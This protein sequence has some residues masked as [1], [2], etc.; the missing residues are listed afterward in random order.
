MRLRGLLRRKPLTPEQAQIYAKARGEEMKRI[1][2]AQA[3]ADTTKLKARAVR[4]A[5]IASS[6]RGGRVAGALVTGG[7]AI[8]KKLENMPSPE[9]YQKR[10][11]KMLEA[12]K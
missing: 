6:G 4:D 3:R 1:Q 12:I 9:E 7:R 8:G 10:Q 2:E 11:K 5:R